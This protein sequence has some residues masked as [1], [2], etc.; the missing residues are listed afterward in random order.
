VVKV[1]AVEYISQPLSIKSAIIFA[2]VQRGATVKN[3]WEDY[4]DLVELPVGKSAIMEN[5]PSF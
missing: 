2:E 3:Q 1:T 4:F 5:E